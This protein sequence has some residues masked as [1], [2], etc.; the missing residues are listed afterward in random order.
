MKDGLRDLS[1]RTDLKERI[2]LE[3]LEAFRIHGIKAITMDDIA[4]SLKMSKRTLYEVFKDK[5][6]LLKESIL[7]HQVHGRKALKELVENSNNVLEVILKCYQGSVE[8][9][10]RVNK[11]FFEDIKKYPTVYELVQSGREQDN[12]VA[13]NF[14]KK[15][16]A[17]GIFRDDINFDI[18][19]TLVREQIKLLMNTHICDSY[20]FLE[21]YESIMFIYLRGISTE[22]GMKE[23][24]EFIIEYRKNKNVTGY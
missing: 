2:I 19:Q 11:R 6:T 4:N 14:L 16:V 22:K 15:G 21:V 9:Y 17:Q 23:L 1:S 18:L 8:A 10:H 13:I 12:Q 24:E 7:Y 5:E 20:P 3:A